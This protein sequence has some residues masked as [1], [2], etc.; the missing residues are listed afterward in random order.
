MILYYL[1]TNKQIIGQFW[2]IDFEYRN[3]IC[4]CISIYTIDF[5]SLGYNQFN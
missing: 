3:K 2:H 5:D 1:L 4:I